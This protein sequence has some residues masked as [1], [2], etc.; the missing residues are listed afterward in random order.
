MS[1][2]SGA[3]LAVENLGLRI[4]TGRGVVDAV[5][6]VSFTLD[7]G[8]TLAIVG[9]SGCGKSMLCRTLLKLLPEKAYIPEDSRIW[10]NG[11]N[12][13]HLPEKAFN[14]IRG[15]EIAM[16][17]QDPM[18]SLN[19][20]MKVGKQIAE[21]L[22]HHLKVRRK[23]AL[24][25]AV[26]L[27]KSM[28]VPSPEHRAGQ[29]PH[30]LSGGLRQR[31]AIA[32]ALAC[33]P[34][35]LIADEPTTALD[36]TVQA[37]ILDLLACAQ[38]ERNMAMILITH[39]LGVAAGRADEIAVMYAGRIVEQAPATELFRNMRMPYTRALMDSIP[40]LENPPHTPLKSINGRPPYLIDPPT[41]CRFSPR[42][43]YAKNRCHEETPPLSNGHVKGHYYACWH[44]LVERPGGR[45]PNGKTPHGVTTN[46]TPHGVTTN[47]C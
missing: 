36:V 7:R 33:E 14:K 13:G 21:T 29:Y 9:E 18:S 24:D 8:R 34:K 19:P 44:P 22:T 6:G 20:V 4:P 31:V 2:D 27:L 15:R 32:I 3:L 46:Q 41:G 17:F 38:A 45:S 39:D 30:Q 42:C 35:L 16:I 26:E 37:E 11:K 25:K 5:D 1:T 10:F 12:I 28:G 47:G 23:P 40:L 43:P